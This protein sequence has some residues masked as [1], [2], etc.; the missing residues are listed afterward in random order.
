MMNEL[1]K[2]DCPITF[3]LIPSGIQ[4]L[5]VKMNI[6]DDCFEFSPSSV[7]S[8]QFGAIVSALYSLFQ[9]ND[10]MHN[11]WNSC[12]YLSNENHEIYREI[13]KVEW[14][15]EGE[16]VEIF[17]SRKLVNKIDCEKDLLNIE[18]RNYDQILKSYT[19]RT[20][21]FCYAVA[22]ACTEV[23]KEYGFY[24]YRY[25][26][27]YDYFRIHQLL[28]IKAFALGNFEARDF[29]NNNSNKLEKRTSFE[30]EIE[31]LLFDM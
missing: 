28:Y 6:N 7:M 8:E 1:Q 3:E 14:D 2:R 21:D 22:K 5:S 31:L 20:K 12:E 9:E 18:I 17:L 24:G 26:T 16:V 11:E 23:L 25:S 30:K 10:D 13:T 19:V 4:F 27:E 15:N 29:I